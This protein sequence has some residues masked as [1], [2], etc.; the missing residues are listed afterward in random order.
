MKLES[1]TL[2]LP[3][4]L[5]ITPPKEPVPLVEEFVKLESLIVTLLL[6]L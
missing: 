5:K 4:E 1:M 3:P 2:K 6:P